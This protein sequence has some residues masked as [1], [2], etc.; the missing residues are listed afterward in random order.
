MQRNSMPMLSTMQLSLF[1]HANT[2]PDASE[3]VLL[4]MACSSTKLDRMRAPSTYTGR[5]VRIVPGTRGAA[6]RRPVFD[7]IRAP[8]FPATRHQDRPLR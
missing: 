1:P 7:P 3:P 6:M 2:P 4:L 5:D 8:R